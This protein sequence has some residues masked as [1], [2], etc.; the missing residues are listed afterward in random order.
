MTN[1]ETHTF[2]PPVGRWT[3]KI[4]G[5]VVTA[6]ALV[7]PDAR[8][9]TVKVFTLC[10]G[11]QIEVEGTPTSNMTVAEF[12]RR[13]QILGSIQHV[14]R[15]ACEKCLLQYQYGLNSYEKRF[16]YS[17]QPSL[18]PVLGIATAPGIILGS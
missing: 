4:N 15:R 11:E 14:T 6:T 16:L 10:S 8:K 3:M 17:S 1:S 13:V 5:L 18:G 2:K 12:V 7:L 9:Y